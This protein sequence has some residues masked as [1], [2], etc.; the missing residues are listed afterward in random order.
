MSSDCPPSLACIN[1]HCR[2][3]CPGTCGLAAL[4]QVINHNPVCSCP[5]HYTGDPFNMCK[6][7]LM[8]LPSPPVPQDPIDP[9]VPSPCGYNARCDNYNGKAQCTCLPNYFGSPPNCKPECVSNSDCAI[10]L[11]CVNMRC[12]EPCLNACGT[13]AECHVTNH[14]PIC[15]CP[16]GFTGDPFT[17]C[18]KQPRKN[19]TFSISANASMLCSLQVYLTPSFFCSFNRLVSPRNIKLIANF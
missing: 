2:D 11:A 15:T 6:P 1:Q 18:Y 14:V 5:P 16:R 19:Q 17:Y 10:N 8:Y 9:C 12:V 4:C 7:I 3:P 13:D